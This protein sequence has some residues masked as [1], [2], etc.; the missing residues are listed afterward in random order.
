MSPLVGIGKLKKGVRP[1]HSRGGADVGG[2][3][4]VAAAASISNEAATA[5]W[6]Q[7]GCAGSGR[8]PRWLMIRRSMA[9]L[10][11][12]VTSTRATRWSNDACVVASAQT[13]SITTISSLELT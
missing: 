9:W 7:V 12:R 3:E 2:S 1:P 10:Y 5:D 13:A 6:S 4:A 8:R 11:A